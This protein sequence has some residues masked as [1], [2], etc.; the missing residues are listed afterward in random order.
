MIGAGRS[1]DPIRF[2]AG[3]D[4]L[5]LEAQRM[6]R[7]NA[8]WLRANPRV[9]LVVEGHCDA[10]SS[11]RYAYAMGMSRALAVQDFLDAQ[12]VT[13]LHVFCVSYGN[14]RPVAPGND[15]DANALNNRAQLV[16]FLQPQ[17]IA[18][19]SPVAAGGKNAPQSAK[20]AEQNPG[21]E[22]PR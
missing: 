10:S 6:L 16:P 15:A 2:S 20:P 21:A 3:S 22:L 19:P 8:Q 13:A 5:D 12:G 18:D 7:E 11:P 1:F 17:G 14:D 9:W 4:E